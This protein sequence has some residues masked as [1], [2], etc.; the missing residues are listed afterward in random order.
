MPITPEA[1]DGTE[2]ILLVEDDDAV[3]EV[4]SRALE[5]RGYRLLLA[6]NGEEALEIAD[7]HQGTIHLVISDVVMPRMG[8]IELFSRMRGWYP[9]IRFMFISGYSSPPIEPQDVE[10]GR[11]RFLQKPFT[12][13]RLMREGRSMLD[14]PDRSPRAMSGISC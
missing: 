14:V 1:L 5:A 9:R 6:K 12:I 4:L 8:G 11:T 13:A 10:D 3:R 2:A 7:E